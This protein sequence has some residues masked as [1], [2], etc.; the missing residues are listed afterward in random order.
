MNAH[1]VGRRRTQKGGMANQDVAAVIVAVVLVALIAFGLLYEQ[2]PCSDGATNARTQD[3]QALTLCV[4]LASCKY[5]VEDVDRGMVL[6][7]QVEHCAIE[8]K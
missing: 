4:E 8:N 6:Q 3:L 1:D 2:D 5:D 7:K